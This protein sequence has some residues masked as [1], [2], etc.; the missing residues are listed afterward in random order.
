M[1]CER[2]QMRVEASLGQTRSLR[3]G[4]ISER[5]NNALLAI[6]GYPADDHRGTSLAKPDSSMLKA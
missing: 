2:V 1:A 4:G 3:A 5:P 6:F